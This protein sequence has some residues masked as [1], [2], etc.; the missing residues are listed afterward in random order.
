MDRAKPL[1]CGAALLAGN[2]FNK[3]FPMRCG[4]GLLH[5][6]QAIAFT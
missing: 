3:L 6:H 1:R 2:I 5:C 4:E